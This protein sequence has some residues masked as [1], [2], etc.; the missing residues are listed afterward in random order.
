[1]VSRVPTLIPCH[2]PCGWRWASTVWRMPRSS[3]TA[4]RKGRLLICSL[5]MVS[6]DDM[7]L[8][9]LLPELGFHLRESSVRGAI[10]V[11]MEPKDD[12]RYLSPP[13]RPARSARRPLPLH[14]PRA[15][16]PHRDRQPAARQQA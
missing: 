12:R 5:L 1:M 15:G 2:S 13:D 6:V 7:Y 9:Y 8:F 16:G 11:L 14:R 3:S 4:S 10:S